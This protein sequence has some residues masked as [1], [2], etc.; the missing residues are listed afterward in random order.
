MN[1]WEISALQAGML[2]AGA[3]ALTGHAL[4]VSHFMQAGG[5][6][7]WM[8][9]PLSLPVAAL[10]FWSFHRLRRAF[11]K[12][13]LVQYLPKILGPVGYAVA[14]LYIAYY[15]TVVIF[16]IRMTTDW[17]VDSILHDTPSWIMSILYMGAVAY[18]AV[19]GLDVLARV[20]QFTLPLLSVLGMLVSVSTMQTKDYGLLLPIF[21]KGLPP[22][23]FTAF[24][25][26]GYFGETSITAMFDAYVQSAD[27]KKLPRAYAFALLFIGMT[28]TGPLAGAVAALGYRVAENMPYPTFQHWLMVR[29]AR[30]FERTDLLAV[31]QWLAGAYVRSGLFLL[32]S[33]KG[34]Y[35][36]FPKSKLEQ[37]VPLKWA[38]AGT[39]GIVVAI[40]EL[41][42][43]NKPFF[44]EFIL[45]IY[46]PAGAWLGMI[47]P[48]IL[49]AIAWI[50][51]LTRPKQGAQT[52]GA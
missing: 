9:G 41:G 1:R 36:L 46:L 6:D 34:V 13:T 16:T 47:L 11:P 3:V 38:L 51:G 12:D 35:Q 32:M 20:V 48:P 52:Y 31:H 10:A 5:R 14:A 30:F 29:Y 43:G 7:A 50:R 25:G 18:I 26:M 39:A 40:S 22:V 17:M 45:N 21:E 49:L 33:V 2:T 37:R 23:L 8:A 24:L 44:D 42:F 4:A 19:G 15:F 27:R 28:L